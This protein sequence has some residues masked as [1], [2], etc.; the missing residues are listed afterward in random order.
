[1]DHN[2]T[3]QLRFLSQYTLNEEN[4]SILNIE[5]LFQIE[6]IYDDI[7]N[8]LINPSENKAQTNGNIG[9]SFGP[10]VSKSN[11]LDKV[12]KLENKVENVSEIPYL[13]CIKSELG[14]KKN[15]NLVDIRE[16]L[17]RPQKEVAKLLNIPS[18]TLHK[19]WKKST[20]KTWP[21]RA[22]SKLNIRLRTLE[23]NYKLTK[24][25]AMET[26]INDC[27]RDLLNEIGIDPIWI[28]T[29]IVKD[30]IKDEQPTIRPC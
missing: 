6:C 19:R 10:Y 18:S 20:N 2:N 9:G 24:I 16:F 11:V 28:K 26:Q 4:L 3:S 25:I 8:S 5:E 23:E 30:I 14:K 22:I 13:D 7:L 17:H 12:I 27:R 15:R 21:Y 1:M 29:T